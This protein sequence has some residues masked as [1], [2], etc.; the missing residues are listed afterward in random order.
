MRYVAGMLLVKTLVYRITAT[1]ATVCV[2]LLVTGDIRAAGA[3]GAFDLF[4]KSLFY[5]LYERAW[6]GIVDSSS[7]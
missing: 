1:V 4:G 6:R 2:A 5:Y 3:L 7:G